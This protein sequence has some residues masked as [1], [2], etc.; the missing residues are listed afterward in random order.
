M[1]LQVPPTFPKGTYNISLRVDPGGHFDAAGLSDF[2]WVQV[3]IDTIVT[4]TLP[5]S[6]EV[7]PGETIWVDVAIEDVD[8]NPVND[9]DVS[10]FLGEDHI[11]DR[12][13]PGTS[14]GFMLTIPTDWTG[15]GSGIHPITVRFPGIGPRDL[16]PSSGDSVNTVHYI[17]NVVFD[18]GGTPEQVVNGTDFTILVILTDEVGNPIRY[19][20]VNLLV[21]RTWTYA[22]TTDSNGAFTRRYRED[23][24]GVYYL[25][26]TLVSTDI[27]FVDST[28]FV[29]YIVPPGPGLPGLLELMVPFVTMLPQYH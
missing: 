19:R 8:N 17:A 28:E 24:V 25:M 7:M 16:L 6:Y 29:M 21:N 2:W 26:A 23:S 18:F 1:T 20:N 12:Y 11:A 15:V 4:V 27:P 22:E 14:A 10:I 13:I 3:P 5:Q 9:T